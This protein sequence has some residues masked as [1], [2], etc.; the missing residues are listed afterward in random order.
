MGGGESESD[1]VSTV[2]ASAITHMISWGIVY[3]CLQTVNLCRIALKHVCLE[4]VPVMAGK[5]KSEDFDKALKFALCCSIGK[6]D[7]M[8]KGE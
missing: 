2:C 6:G 3:H 5:T 4:L 1:M 7:F 8:L